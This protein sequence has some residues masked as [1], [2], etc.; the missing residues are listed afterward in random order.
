MSDE[1]KQVAKTFTA[2]TVAALPAHAAGMAVGGAL[3]GNKLDAPAQKITGYMANKLSRVGGRVGKWA[4]THKNGKVGL[5]LAVGAGI[6]SAVAGGIADLAT[7][8]ATLHGKVK[9]ES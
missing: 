7:L 9:K 8:K 5:G 2:Q 4:A 6:G 1:N 3:L